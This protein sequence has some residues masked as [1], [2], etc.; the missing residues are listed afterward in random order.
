LY[1]EQ[2]AFYE[3]NGFITT[4]TNWPPVAGG[5]V[6]ILKM[7]NRVSGPAESFRTFENP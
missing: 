6:W 7:I 4:D 2:M 1:N 5:L 3:E